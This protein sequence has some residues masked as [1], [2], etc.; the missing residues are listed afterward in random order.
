MRWIS[1]ILSLFLLGLAIEA[2]SAQA[3]DIFIDDE[4]S[5][6]DGQSDKDDEDDSDEF[7]SGATTT[8]TESASVTSGPVTSGPVTSDP[9][10]S[11]PVTSG[12]VTSGPMTSGPVVPSEAPTDENEQPT[13]PHEQPGSSP[14]QDADHAQGEGTSVEAATTQAADAPSPPLV[15]VDG[16]TESDV[17]T[18]T[19]TTGSSSSTVDGHVG[20]HVGKAHG[21]MGQPAVVEEPPIIPVHKEEVKEGQRGPPDMPATA[22]AAVND[23]PFE[24]TEVL[25]AVIAGGA[26]GVVMAALL[27]AFLVH[28]IRKKDTGSY[29]L[30]PNKPPQTNGDYQ[31]APTQEI[32]A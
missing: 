23:S 7:G 16:S 4:G 2:A 6:V 8:D 32:Y 12:P 13:S 18:A 11:G 24:K 9:V 31:I 17:A 3:S 28:R 1:V 29:A 14:P 30:D 25:A 20:G 22:S 10:T 26:V 15:P 5:G 27:V 19:T 21:R